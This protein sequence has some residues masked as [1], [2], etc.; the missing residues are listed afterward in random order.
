MGK[1]TSGGVGPMARLT[2]EE[3]ALWVVHSCKSDN[4][5][6]RITDPNLLARVSILLNAN[7]QKDEK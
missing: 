2:P 3:L 7:R 6:V 1:P 4:L 5:P